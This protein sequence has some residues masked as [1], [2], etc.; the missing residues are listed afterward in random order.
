MIILN[1]FMMALRTLVA[2]KMRSGLTMLGIIIGV[3]A[4]I[5]L[6]S[7]GRGTQ[8]QIVSR[9]ESMGT[10]L[11]IVRPGAMVAG[12][13]VQTTPAFLTM[14]DVKALSKP[15]AAPAVAMVAPEVSMN[16]QVVAGNQTTS[17]RVLGV[18]P[19]YEFVRISP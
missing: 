1:S 17:A 13:M 19:E 15:G 16:V 4:V 9:F 7:V 5:S 18:T 2:N 8:E 14:D 10:N 3:S 6:M 12:R 11:L